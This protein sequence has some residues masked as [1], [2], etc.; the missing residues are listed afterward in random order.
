[1]TQK[2]K[3]ILLKYL[4]MVL[5]Y[6]VKLKIRQWKH[7]VELT[8]IKH[9]VL[10]GNYIINES[11]ELD[12]IKPYLK[13]LSSMTDEEREAFIRIGVEH[14]LQCIEIDNK[15]ESFMLGVKFHKDELEYLLERQYDV[16]GLI[17]MG[18]AIEVTEENNPYK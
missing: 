12:D 5:P 14:S 2:E 10:S 11:Y 9:S 3:D 16:Y 18:L 15:L 13:P 17:P 6:G 7:P 1:M 4:C 8:I